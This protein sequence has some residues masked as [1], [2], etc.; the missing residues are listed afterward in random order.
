MNSSRLLLAVGLASMP[1][2]HLPAAETMPDKTGYSLARPVPDALLRELST[3]RPDKTESPYSV[4][5]GRF[6]IELDVL[7]YARDHDKSGSGDTVAT[8]WGMA[9][10]LKLGLR[11]DLDVQ[12]MLEP[13]RNVRT[14]DRVAR[15]TARQTG[16]GDTTVRLKKNFWGNDGGRTAFAVM[17]FVKLP[18]NRDGLGNTSVEGGVI[19]PLAM[20]LSDGWGM[21]LMTEVDVLRNEAG[22]GRH[23][24]FVNTITFGHDIVGDLAGYVE[25]FSEISAESGARW[26]GTVDCGL[27]YGLNKNLQLDVGAN[28][29]VTKSADDLNLFVGV[30]RRF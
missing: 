26:V 7:T 25:F 21:G 2:A 5:A 14:E 18:T 3:D 23:A 15:T 6:Q 10:V 12:L 28:I 27:T 30:S 9:P 1:V 8:A 4:D 24:S 29:G 19:F 16:F 11:H 17:P 13:Y 20:E 22:G